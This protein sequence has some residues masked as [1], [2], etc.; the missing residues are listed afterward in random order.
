MS[1]RG[2]KHAFHVIYAH[3]YIEYATAGANEYIQGPMFSDSL[4]LNMKALRFFETSVIT[5]QHSHKMAKSTPQALI[6]PVQKL[7]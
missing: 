2:K 1:T 7:T 3:V 6:R 4:S 5:Q